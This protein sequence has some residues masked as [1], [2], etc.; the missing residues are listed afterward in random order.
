MTHG[1][2]SPVPLRGG[3]ILTPSPELPDLRR[4]APVVRVRT[5]AGDAAWLVTRYD[6]ARALWGDPRL[7]TSHPTPR[8]AA[9]VSDSGVFSGPFGN[10]ETERA[11]HAVMRALIAPSFGAR[12]IARLETFV[13]GL[14]DTLVETMQAEH[15]RTGGPV[16]LHAHLSVPLPLRVIAALLGVPDEEHPTFRALTDRALGLR[17][18]D[19]KQAMAQMRRYCTELAER[20]RAEPGEDV[21][22]D[23]VAAQREQPSLPDTMIAEICAM[24]LMAGHE[25]VVARI[26]LGVLLLAR[27]PDVVA[28]LAA[29][30]QD[31]AVVSGV[32]EEV[33][34]R[35]M[36]GG[37]GFP[38]YAHEDIVVGEGDDAVSISAGDCV[39]LNI[40]AANHDGSAFADPDVFDPAR[41]R[42]PHLSFGRGPHA[43]VGAT[44]ARIEMRRVF[45]TLAARL[46][47]LQPAVAVEDL[48]VHTDRFTGG[49]AGLPVTW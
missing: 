36:V 44:L 4:A 12:R 13:A 22:S 38:R 18:E 46:P 15:G 35:T 11:D 20:K 37:T 45:T 31:E 29:A 26:D 21:V 3:G 34:R 48:P 39:L 2:L 19:P 14:V 25:T 27:R 41:P 17:G 1:E 24:L 43:C 6:A 40:G 5:P 49:L 10:Y 23:L 32:V 8:S 47:G 16:D 7:G 30:P 42:V 33:L 28:A 9:R